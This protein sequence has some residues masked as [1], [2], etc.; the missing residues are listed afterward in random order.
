MDHEVVIRGDRALF[1]RPDCTDP[2]SF[3]VPPPS[4]IRGILEAVYWHPGL[5]IDTLSIAVLSPIR[6][7]REGI[8]EIRGSRQADEK[9]SPLPKYDARSD[10][11]TAPTPFKRVT[12][13]VVLREPSWR[14]RFRICT[15]QGSLVDQEKADQ[16]MNQRL[17]RGTFHSVPFLGVARYG[18]SVTLPDGEEPIDQSRDFGMVIH[19]FDY[20]ERMPIQHVFHA[21]MV[22]GV[23]VV[24][25]FYDKVLSQSR[26]V[27]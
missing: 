10:T 13:C 11:F 20:R 1:A 21:K 18:A 26:S 6:W 9:G 17:H 27:A 7:D 19:D 14:V 5:Y 4:A 3:P 8:V 16:I 12:S 25:S 24:P 2:L 15:M 23:I 22:D